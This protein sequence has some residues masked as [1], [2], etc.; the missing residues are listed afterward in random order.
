MVTLKTTWGLLI[1]LVLERD[2]K[3]LPLVPNPA[4]VG[5][6]HRFE[7]I[8]VLTIS[9]NPSPLFRTVLERI[10]FYVKRSVMRSH[11]LSEVRS[12]AGY[13]RVQTPCYCRQL[14]LP[15]HGSFLANEFH[16]PFNRAVQQF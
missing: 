11:S 2:L 7:Y 1:Q 12:V 16:Q 15:T 5:Y 13:V 10:I 4:V 14:L 6:S 3:P 9:L 8:Y